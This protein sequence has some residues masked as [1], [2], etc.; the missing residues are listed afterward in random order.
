M[1]APADDA[2]RICLWSGP[3]NISTALMYAFAQ[4]ADTTVVD[5]RFTGFGQRILPDGTSEI[6]G[7]GDLPKGAWALLLIAESGQM[8]SLPNEFG[9]REAAL[10]P[11]PGRTQGGRIDQDA[12]FL[13]E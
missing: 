8:W 3:R 10:L 7:F 2:V 5:V 13:I 9:D 4:R 11:P 12:Y 6:L 1:T